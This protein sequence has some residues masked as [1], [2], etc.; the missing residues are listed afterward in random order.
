MQVDSK[1]NLIDSFRDRTLMWCM[2]CSFLCVSIDTVGQY[3]V[4]VWKG[5]ICKSLWSIDCSGDACLSEQ[6]M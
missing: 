5:T 2:S 6:L 3:P 1:V 4:G